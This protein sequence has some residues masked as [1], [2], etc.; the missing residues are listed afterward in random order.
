MSGASERKRGERAGDR[1]AWLF[2]HRA[3]VP[4]DAEPYYL[5]L[6][7]LDDAGDVR[8][9]EAYAVDPLWYDKRW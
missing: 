6:D 7:D 3:N 2:V 8:V 5:T 9:K 4:S 1:N